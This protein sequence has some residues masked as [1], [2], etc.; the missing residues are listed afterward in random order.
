MASRS[1][2]RCHKL[3]EKSMAVTFVS[4]SLSYLL[5]HQGTMTRTAQRAALVPTYLSHLPPSMPTI[6]SAPRRRPALHR[7]LFPPCDTGGEETPS[8]R[9]RTAS[10]GAVAPALPDRPHPRATPRASRRAG[11]HAPLANT[12][13]S[14]APS[15]TRQPTPHGPPRVDQAT[16][17]SRNSVI[18]TT[19]RQSTATPFSSGPG[20]LLPLRHPGPPSRS[21]HITR[22]LIPI[23]LRSALRSV[24]R[25]GLSLDR[26]V[27]IRFATSFAL[28]FSSSTRS[29]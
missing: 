21:R 18:S 3:L 9:R 14:L 17:S 16:S 20:R 26:R 5:P 10:S 25:F 7:I 6:C 28:R 4:L 12:R 2:F 22:H 24:L 23:D 19:S 1:L 8:C 15:T 13:A 11:R 27:D 29:S